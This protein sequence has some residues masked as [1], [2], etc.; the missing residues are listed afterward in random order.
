MKAVGTSSRVKVCVCMSL[1]SNF[2]CVMRAAARCVALFPFAPDAVHVNVV[3]DQ[4]GQIHRNRLPRKSG[5]A[6][7]APP[8]HHRH[9]LVERVGRAGTF[10]HVMDPLAAG[11]AFH[12]LNR[13]F[14][15]D[16]DH[17]VR[18]QFEPNV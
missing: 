8:V 3:P 2:F 7:P 9:R 4:L 16:V 11:D 6:D 18:A 15:S 12:R 1:A 17:M 5:K 10:D 14:R 13:V